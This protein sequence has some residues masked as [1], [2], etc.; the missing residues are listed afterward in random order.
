MIQDCNLTSHTYIRSTVDAIVA[1]MQNEYFGCFQGLHTRLQICLE[2]WIR[3]WMQR[4]ARRGKPLWFMKSPCLSKSGCWICRLNNLMWRFFGLRAMDR[5]RPWLDIDLCIDAAD[6]SHADRLRLMAAINE[7]LLPWTVDLALRHE[8]PPDLLSCAP[9]RSMYLLDPSAQFHMG[10]RS[11]VPFL[12]Q[13]LSR[14]FRSCVCGCGSSPSMWIRAHSKCVVKILVGAA[15][16]GEVGGIAPSQCPKRFCC[17]RSWSDQLPQGDPGCPDAAGRAHPG[18]L[19]AVSGG[20]RDPE[21]MR[22]PAWSG[23]LCTAS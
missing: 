3:W 12:L 23:S 4:A 17:N 5:E 21:Q 13:G 16:M 14:Q 10:W 6:L 22:E 18:L 20:V 11:V 19:P 9:L 1:V 15:T 2:Q 8:L 7:L